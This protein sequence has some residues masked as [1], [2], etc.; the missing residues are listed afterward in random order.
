MSKKQSMDL[1]VK[2]QIENA[3]TRQNI[4]LEENNGY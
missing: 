3:Q 4:A 2:Y 1:I